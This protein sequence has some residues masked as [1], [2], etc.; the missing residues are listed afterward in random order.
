MKR[1]LIALA[2]VALPIVV[3]A[4]ESYECDGVVVN[5]E[6]RQPGPTILGAA[7]ID[8]VGKGYTVTL[9][10]DDTDTRSFT[11]YATP[12]MSSVPLPPGSFHSESGTDSFDFVPR[13]NG[14][15]QAF[16][17]DLTGTPNQLQL[18]CYFMQ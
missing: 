15:A 7:T 11:F 5:L 2:L 12:R 18:T 14:K 17:T 10:P 13:P 1:T 16:L 9:Y 3:Q 6:T 4:D 8:H